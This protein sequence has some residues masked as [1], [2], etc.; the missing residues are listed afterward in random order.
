MSFFYYLDVII[1]DVKSAV[2]NEQRPCRGPGSQPPTSLSPGAPADGSGQN[3][4][5]HFVR[6]MMMLLPW[7]LTGLGI[8]RVGFCDPSRHTWT[9]VQVRLSWAALIPHAWPR[10]PSSFQW[11]GDHPVL[12]CSSEVLTC[13]GGRLLGRRYH[14]GWREKSRKLSNDGCVCHDCSDICWDGLMAAFL[15]LLNPPFPPIKGANNWCNWFCVAKKLNGFVLSLFL[16]LLIHLQPFR[17]ALAR[18]LRSPSNHSLISSVDAGVSIYLRIIFGSF[19]AL[20]SMVFQKA[21]RP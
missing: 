10:R 14:W 8:C 5:H 12:N 21:G 17:A 6:K 16:S 15:F 11:T 1:T 2:A 4:S 19:T 20:V 18:S 7:L 3:L 9:L 13:G